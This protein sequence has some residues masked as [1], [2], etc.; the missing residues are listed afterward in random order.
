ML[1]WLETLKSNKRVRKR[2]KKRQECDDLHNMFNDEDG[3]DGS[4]R[5]RRRAKRLLDRQYLRSKS[6]SW[7]LV[8]LRSTSPSRL[9]LKTTSL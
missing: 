7:I 3:D 6:S 4:F 5:R 8:L 9:S 2:N 1:L